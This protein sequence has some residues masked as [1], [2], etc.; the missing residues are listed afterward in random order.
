MVELV[1]KALQIFDGHTS[2]MAKAW[3]EMNNLNK[4]VFILQ[5]L[6]FSLPTSLAI[7]LEAQFMKRWDMM[8]T[9][10]HKRIVEPV[11]DER[12]GDTK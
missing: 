1:L 3:L 12:H 11:F 2:A 7:R 9:N 5:D 10:C 4:Q 6:V 8:L